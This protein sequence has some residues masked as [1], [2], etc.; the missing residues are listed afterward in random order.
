MDRRYD[1]TAVRASEKKTSKFFLLVYLWH[2]R[3]TR[4]PTPSKS[5]DGSV[6]TIKI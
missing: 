5:Q 4:T 3:A 1:R 2:L 6:L